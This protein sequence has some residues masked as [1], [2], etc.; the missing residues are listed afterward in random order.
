[1]L[2]FYITQDPSLQDE[3]TWQ[4]TGG[5]DRNE[6][7]ALF[8]DALAYE[9]FTP[10]EDESEWQKKVESLYPL[11]SRACD[12]YGDAWYE[13][14]EIEQLRCECLKALETTPNEIAANVLTKII[15]ACVE[16]TGRRRGLL[17]AC[18]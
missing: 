2:D 9:R 11:L 8:Y 13:A 17:M 6:W 5:M 10:G 12:Y 16:A 18:D 14:E 3:G 15:H 1:M 7:D 4:H